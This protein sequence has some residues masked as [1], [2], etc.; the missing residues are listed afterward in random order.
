MFWV[1]KKVSEEVKDVVWPK[2]KGFGG[3]AV[4]KV[5]GGK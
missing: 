3:K 5:E 2:V 1:G 4:E